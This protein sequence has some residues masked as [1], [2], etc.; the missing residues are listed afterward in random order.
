MCTRTTPA[1]ANASA[2]KATEPDPQNGYA[3]TV[4]RC[5][6]QKGLDRRQ[7]RAGQR[8]QNTLPFSIYLRSKEGTD[9]IYA[10][11]SFEINGTVHHLDE[12]RVL[13]RQPAQGSRHVFSLQTSSGSRNAAGRDQR[14]QQETYGA[15][16]EVFDE[17]GKRV[18]PTGA[19]PEIR[20]STKIQKEPSIRDILQI[21]S[22][23]NEVNFTDDFR[24]HMRRM[25]IPS[26]DC[27]AAEC[28]WR[29]S[30]PYINVKL[31]EDGFYDP[32]SK[33]GIWLAGD[34]WFKGCLQ[35]PDG[36]IKARGQ[37]YIRIPTINDCD[38]TQR[39][40]FCGSAQNTTSKADGPLLFEDS[41]E[42]AG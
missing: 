2:G 21:T 25:I 35:R 27:A 4:S 29:L 40:P 26:N 19:V 38:Y 33:K 34:Y 13:F 23:A 22:L 6:L 39:P 14:P 41:A 31:M 3:E 11:N 8:S 12:Q 18:K 36:I 20:K 7:V 9:H 5:Q 28:I 30:Y 24:G 15:A 16:S 37:D 42:A 10:G 1:R 32:D 17:L